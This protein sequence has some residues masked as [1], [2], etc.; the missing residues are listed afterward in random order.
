M[1]RST[2]TVLTVMM[3]AGAAA[4]QAQAIRDNSGFYTRQVARND[5][6]SSG[7]EPLG[8]TINLFGKIRSAAYVNNNGNLTFDEALGT[9]TPFG[10]ENTSREIIAPFFADVD[11]RPS[12][13]NV[14]T[15]GQDVVNGHRAFAANYI[16]VGYYSEHTDKLDSFQVVL[17]ERDDQNPGDFDIEF[18]YA[19]IQWETGD[20]SGGVNGY[21]GTPAVVGWSNGTDTSFQLP[22]SMISG[23]FLDGGPYSLVLQQITGSTLNTP[24]ATSTAGRLVFRARDGVINPGLTITG[25]QFPDG[26]VGVPYSSQLLIAGAD[27]PYTYALQ[28]DVVAPPGL[29]LNSSGVLTGTPTTAGTF[30]FT[31]QVTGQSEDGPLT[32]SQRGS[33]TIRPPKLQITS[34]CP[35]PS[36]YVGVSYFHPLTATGSPGGYQWSADPA[37]LPPGIGLSASGDLAGTPTTPGTYMMNLEVKSSTDQYAQPAQQMCRINVN[38]AT[39]QLTSSCQLPRGTVGIPFSAAIQAT[40]GVAPYQF[41]ITGQLPAGTA[42]TNTGVIAGTPQYWGLY[43]FKIQTT[44]AQNTTAEQDCSWI[45]DGQK[46]NVNNVCPLPDA[47]TGVPY[48][49]TLP[50][51]YQW[52]LV[53]NFPAGLTLSPNGQIGGTPMQAGPNQFRLIAAN[54]SGEQSSVACSLT[55]QRSPL[56]VFG[57]PVPNARVGEP[58]SASLLGVGGTGPYTFS[59]QGSLPSGVQLSATGQISGTPASAGTFPFTVSVRDGAAG[60]ASQACSLTVD[61]AYLRF[62][63]SCPLPDATF[64]ASYSAQL[65]ADGG[66]APYSFSLNGYLPAGLDLGTD[67]KISGTPTKLGGRTFSTKVTDANGASANATCSVAVVAPKLPAI[68]LADLPTTIAPAST[69]LAATV[70][71]AKAYT[72]AVSGRVAMKITPDTASTDA[73]ANTPDPRVAFEDGQISQLFTIPAG[74]TSVTLPVTSTGTV[75]STIE[76][77]IQDL[78]SQGTAIAQN[79][80][81]KLTRIPAEVPTISSACYDR[82]DTG[83]TMTINGIST[84]RELSHAVLTIPSL[85]SKDMTG[86][87]QLVSEFFI[88]NDGKITV[89]LTPTALAYFSSPANV[90]QGG[91]FSVTV[92]VP[93]DASSLVTQQDD[94]DP[95]QQPVDLG[96]VEANIF[97]SVGEAGSQSL[98]KCQ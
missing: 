16:D 7:L 81:H 33:V 31:I 89:D 63:N 38:P 25:G 94:Q 2:A 87:E 14:V 77:S 95:A 26:V 32:T 6:L 90:R 67:G 80:T 40:G 43:L 48:S 30:S 21:G 65:T 12:G 85:A 75:A 93:V 74:S 34:S 66:T 60:M 42:L 35:A 78:R 76:M 82:T 3:L 44:D 22:G 68:S 52:S 11:T 59:S 9:F 73:V 72:S 69:N 45:V 71:L 51:D 36:A 64:G 58:F 39:V 53:G 96:T 13:S 70:Q 37:G 46:F 79:P 20:A 91:A 23:A 47:S 28:P 97:N 54:S 83:L 27:P 4:L 57:C 50:A 18:N 19:Q 55:V 92:N 84:T 86:L 61:A 10:L 49:A 98:P 5:D 88:S 15:F 17:I 62:T 8:F 1:K 29:S 24:G 41:S 56:S